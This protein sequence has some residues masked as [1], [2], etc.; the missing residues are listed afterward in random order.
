MTL[1]QHEQ[2][3][4]PETAAHKQNSVMTDFIIYT[5]AFPTVTYQKVFCEKGLLIDKLK[6][7]WLNY[8]KNN[9]DLNPYNSWDIKKPN[10]TRQ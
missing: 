5:C 4:D 2:Y 1:S 9:L 6:T 3:Q 7:N 10:K 8:N